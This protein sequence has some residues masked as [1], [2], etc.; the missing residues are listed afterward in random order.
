MAEPVI[1]LTAD[2]SHTLVIPEL[3]ESYH[4]VNGAFSE[5]DYVYLQMGYRELDQRNPL[6]VLE[7]GFGTG[8]NCL[9]TAM[10]A[11]IRQIYT[12]YNTIEK[13]PL[14]EGIVQ[15]LNYPKIRGKGSDVIF[16][17]IHTS[18]WE[19]ETEISPWFELRKM[20]GDF[21]TDPLDGISGVD[22]VYF[23]A[24][25][26]DKQPEIWTLAMF[27]KINRVMKQGGVFV[28]YSAKGRVRRDLIAAGFKIERLP[29]ACGKREMLRG[30]KAK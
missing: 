20:K 13:H 7:I 2:G 8:L 16:R 23:D 5:S 26:P 18:A 30:I 25:G 15:S 1:I 11:E 21:I 9:L 22:L 29:G 19:K 27:E 6:S 10:E 17:K 24:F 28:T 4:S 14:P 12:V 3:Q